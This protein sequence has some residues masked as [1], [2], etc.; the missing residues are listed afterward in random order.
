MS[1]SLGWGPGICIF[2]NLV[3]FFFL[4]AL[5]LIVRGLPR[6]QALELE[7]QKC[8][9]VILIQIIIS[10]IL[11]KNWVSAAGY[12]IKTTGLKMCKC[13]KVALNRSN[14]LLQGSV[15]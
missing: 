5:G 15:A 1:G 8:P 14:K 12:R 11:V 3:F 9:Q 2:L 6:A 13:P 7:L 4:A 10:H